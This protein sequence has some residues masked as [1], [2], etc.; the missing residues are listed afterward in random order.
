MKRFFEILGPVVLVGG[1]LAGFALGLTGEGPLGFRLVNGLYIAT[2][3][4]APGIWILAITH[5]D[6]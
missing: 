3:A 4:A 1:V 6:S 2:W 5:S